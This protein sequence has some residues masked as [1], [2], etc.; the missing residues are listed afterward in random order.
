M[1]KLIFFEFDRKFLVFMFTPNQIGLSLYI[2]STT[3][4]YLKF[5]RSFKTGINNQFK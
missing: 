1:L 3:I 5:R 2:F 4:S